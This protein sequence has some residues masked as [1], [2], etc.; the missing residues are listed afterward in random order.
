MGIRCVGEGT[1]EA[2]TNGSPSDLTGCAK[3]WILKTGDLPSR[4][5]LLDLECERSAARSVHG[6]DEEGCLWTT[7]QLDDTL[8]R[9]A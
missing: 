6:V 8:F 9:K 2:T 1:V 5:A 3:Q 4:K 7:R